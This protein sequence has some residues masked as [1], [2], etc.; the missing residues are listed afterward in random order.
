MYDKKSKN[1][2][3]VFN[4]QKDVIVIY[5][6]HC[7]IKLLVCKSKWLLCGEGKVVVF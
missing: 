2:N 7:V 4:L 1:Y 3:I 5:W 6:C